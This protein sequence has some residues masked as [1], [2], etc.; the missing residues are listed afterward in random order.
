MCKFCD[1]PPHGYGRYILVLS[2]ISGAMM[3]PIVSFVD[4][5]VHLFSVLTSALW[6]TYSV[7]CLSDACLA[8]RICLQST[9]MTLMTYACTVCVGI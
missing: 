7:S 1:L 5:M 9:H 4:A 2:C 3:A 8:S 6:L